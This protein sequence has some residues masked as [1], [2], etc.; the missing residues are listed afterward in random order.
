MH[1]GIRAL[2]SAHPQRSS[3]KAHILNP[4]V[5]GLATTQT[6]PVHHQKKEVISCALP[7]A[8]SSF[9][10]G[11]DLSRIE[12]VLPSMRISDRTLYITRNGEVRH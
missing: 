2:Q 3:I 6:V 12:E 8:L 1:P 11:L 7:A 9:Q 10:K 4:H 5:H